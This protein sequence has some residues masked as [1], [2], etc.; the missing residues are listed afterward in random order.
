MSVLKQFWEENRVALIPG[1]IGGFIHHHAFMKEECGPEDRR[2][3]SLKLCHQKVVKDDVE[4]IIC[5][6]WRQSPSDAKDPILD[7]LEDEDSHSD[8][9]DE[10]IKNDFYLALPVA[11]RTLN[12]KGSFTVHQPSIQEKTKDGYSCNSCSTHTDVFCHSL[13][14]DYDLCENCYRQ[15]ELDGIVDKYRDNMF[16]G[17]E[18]FGWNTYDV[19]DDVE[20]IEI[21]NWHTDPTIPT[22]PTDPTTN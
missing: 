13:T 2:L 14:Y 10:K 6:I 1:I 22:I 21:E 20:V 4:V 17:K 15:E 9:E 7:G 16:T 11:H 8:S 12:S 19:P 5:V 3:Q 18:Y